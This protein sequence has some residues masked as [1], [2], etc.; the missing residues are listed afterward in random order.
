MDKSIS[1]IFIYV[2]LVGDVGEKSSWCREGFAYEAERSCLWYLCHFLAGKRGC[3]TTGKVE[4]KGRAARRLMIYRDWIKP[5]F[6]RCIC[7]L[8]WLVIG[9]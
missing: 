7:V 8:C 4:P 3:E 1:A 5:D 9:S 2:G 6:W